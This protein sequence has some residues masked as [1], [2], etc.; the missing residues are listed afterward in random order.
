MPRLSPL[1]YERPVSVPDDF[2]DR[3]RSSY[4]VALQSR[5]KL[6]IAW[7]CATVAG[8]LILT[9]A[10]IAQWSAPPTMIV[11]AVLLAGYAASGYFVSDKNSIQFADSLYY[12]G[13]LWALFSLIA[14]LVIWP[15]PRLTA[16]A[17]LTTFGSALAATFCGLLL[18]MAMIHFQDTLPQEVH[19]RRTI[20]RGIASL[21]LQINEATMEMSAFRDRAAGD[22]GRALYDLVHT[23]AEVREKM[24]DQ[25]LRMATSMSEGFE[26]S[27]REILGRLSAIRIPQE[28]LTDEVMK[29]VAALAKQGDHVAKASQRLEATLTH[30]GE[31]VGAFVESLCRSDAS[32]QVGAAINELSEQIK[33]RSAQFREMTTALEKGR[34]EL[35]GQLDG[36]QSLRS[37]VSMISARLA[38][39][40]KEM[41]DVSS[42]S[43]S[44]EL[45]KGLASVQTAIGSSL[46][47][48]KAIESTMR[49]VLFFM[50]ERL[51]EE[52]SG[53]RK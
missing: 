35:N 14:A 42:A 16:D 51:T 4:D 22:L 44:T 21:A 24:A 5:I 9:Y 31:T 30:A 52:H 20:D 47:A 17:V 1:S 32:I 15:P 45:R 39:F 18:R 26:S 40:E 6:G 34:L 27:L 41:N 49:D 13:F 19:S 50:K 11:L 53:G 3:D 38:A 46:E 7:M 23:L 2:E 37:A 43:M 29:L 12:M 25:H 36:L 8:L 28:M 10:S 33:A 48:S